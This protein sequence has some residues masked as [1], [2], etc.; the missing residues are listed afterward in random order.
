[1]SLTSIILVDLLS[2][3]RLS[4]TFGLIICFRGVSSII[5]PPLAGMMYDMTNS[6]TEVFIAAG[7]L[8][9]TSA[10][11]SAIVHKYEKYQ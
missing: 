1:M 8:I 3:E 11:I 2:L 9:I 10:A 5:G 4:T 7:I 6:Y